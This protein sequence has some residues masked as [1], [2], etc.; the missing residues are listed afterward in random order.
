M[1]GVFLAEDAWV[2]SKE[3]TLRVEF[4]SVVQAAIDA[5]LDASLMTPTYQGTSC[6]AIGAH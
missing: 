6:K 2:L 4:D 3:D 1:T 5:E